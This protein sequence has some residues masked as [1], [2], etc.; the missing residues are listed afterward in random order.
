MTLQPD[1]L[2]EKILSTTQSAL[3]WKDKDRRF[4]GANKAFL[5]YYGFPSLESILGKTDEDMGWHEEDEPFR[6]DELHVL[7]TGECTHHVRG[8]CMRQ[9]EMREIVA[10]KSPLYENGEIIGLVG[11]F[12]DVTEAVASHKKI[13]RLNE[14]LL[15]AVQKAQDADHAKTVFLSTLSHDLRTPLNGILGFAELAL[16]TDDAALQRSYLEKIAASGRILRN[17]IDRTLEIAH[18]AAG[19]VEVQIEDVNAHALLNDLVTTIQPLAASKNLHFFVS[20]Q[21]RESCLVR[22][23]PALLQKIL[24]NLLS[25]AVKFTPSGGKI[26]FQA[27]SRDGRQGDGMVHCCFVVR[28]NGIGMSEE[29]QRRMYEPFTQETE[30]GYSTDAEGSG[31]GLT[32]TRQA[33]ELLGGHLSVASQKGHGTFF[34]LELSL[35]SGNAAYPAEDQET[36]PALQGVRVLL[37]EDNPSNQEITKTLLELRGLQVTCADDGQQGL[38]YMKAAEPYAFDVILMDIRMPHM[39][40]LEATRAIRALDRPDAKHIPIIALSANAFQEDV[41]A[42]RAAGMNKH[43]T[44]PFHVRHLLACMKSLIQ[45]YHRIQKNE[46]SVTGIDPDML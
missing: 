46:E 3:F 36:D 43:L 9:G 4:L 26:E 42:S 16:L 27:S 23:D 33:V 34:T 8:R 14:L 5:D 18:I 25:N 41:A 37:C 19:K 6:N 32:I 39:D 2:L 38:A 22:T 29:F 45:K 30:A 20:N 1:D 10:S 11:N 21:L 13:K 28:D 12:E 7:E 17:L 35:E 40:G 44:K 31:L 15:D 24:L